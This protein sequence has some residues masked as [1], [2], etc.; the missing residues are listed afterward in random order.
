MNLF[1]FGTIVEGDF[2]TG[3]IETPMKTQRSLFLNFY[4]SL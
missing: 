1:K 3:S 4:L 2:F